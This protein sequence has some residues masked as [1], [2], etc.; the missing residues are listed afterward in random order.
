MRLVPHSLVTA[1]R[2]GRSDDYRSAPC[3]SE[4]VRCL[5]IG[6]A[7][8]CLL[9][10]P[11]LGAGAS[12]QG[13]RHLHEHGHPAIVLE[14]PGSRP[15]R[16]VTGAASPGPPGPGRVSTTPTNQ[17]L[18]ELAPEDT[19]SANLFDLRGRT[20]TFT[21]DGQGGYSRSVRSVAWEDDIGPAVADG[22][23]IRL[24]SF[25]FDFAS[26]R[27][28]SFFVSGRG[29]ISF[30]KRLTY[31]HHGIIENRYGT[32]REIAAKFVT[33]P[34]ISPLYKPY[35]GGWSSDEWTDAYGA[36]QHVRS[37]P[38]RVV[39]TWVTTEP[40]KYVHGVPPDEPSRFQVVLRADGSVQFNYQN[41]I[42]FGD[43]IVGLFPDEPDEEPTKGALIASIVDGS[44]PQLAGHLDLLEVAIYESST[45]SAIV[46]WT[47]RDQITAPPSGTR[48]SYRLHLDADEPYFE[49]D[50]DEEFE[51]QVDLESDEVRTRGGRLLPRKAGNRIALL[52]EDPG[53]FGNSMHARAGA[54]QFDDSGWVSGESLDPVLLEVPD[55][56]APMTDLSRSDSGF[57]KRQSE[58]FH[59]RGG[60]DYAD[61]V[62]RVID[63]LGDE[64]DFFVFHEEFVLDHQE[65]GGGRG[66][67]Y[68]SRDV[69]GIGRSGDRSPPCGEGRLKFG[70]SDWVKGPDVFYGGARR[71]NH[72]G[73]ES[74][75]L[76]FAHEITHWWTAYASYR[77][78]GMR[79]PLF[80]EYC[81]CHWRPELH[82]PAAFPWDPTSPGP[83]GF[84]SDYI[85]G[86]PAGFWRENADGTF[87]PITDYRGGGHSWLDLYMMGLADTDEVPDMFILRN[88][89]P[90]PGTDR[91]TGQ[92]ETVSIEQVVAAE[93]PRE[94]PAELAQK[95]FNVA[96][97]YVT[98]PGRT[99]DPDLLDLQREL[100]DRIV[101]H[102]AHVTGGRSR[103]TTTVP[104]VG[105]V[106]NRAPTVVGTLADRVVPVDGTAV[107]E[108]R[109]AFRDPDGDPLTYD[110]TSSAPAVASVAVSG[111]TVTLRA[112]AAGTAT[113]TVTATDVGASNTPATLAFRVTVREQAAFTDDPIVPGVTPVRAVHFTELR[114]RI[115]L[116]RS[117]AGLRPFSWTDPILTT[118]LTPVRLTHL[119]ELRGAL[120]A[121]Y[122]A[123]GRTA[124]TFTDP[125]P[126][127]GT[128]PI[129]AAHLTELRAAVLAL[130]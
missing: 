43:G 94:P 10:L 82:T 55:R 93:G 73:F 66:F 40:V 31:R 33:V 101:E 97:V 124:P 64:F 92:K 23:E 18:V 50:G 116:L 58:V 35:L 89:Q 114:E 1:L 60:L 105:D 9:A 78:N 62:C 14:G 125:A 4:C 22:E 28:D 84:M 76:L 126:T 56:A 39:V 38:D 107:V 112:V 128:T 26:R 45:G 127:A 30:G 110:A 95:V 42:F 130:R 75:L 37:S 102:W 65:R 81:G 6:V 54:H 25:T 122:T 19:T 8:A 63:I 103:V 13:A 11:L 15:V 96:F 44:N 27:W 36:T 83:G 57:S 46:E 119:L 90:V 98:E 20:L 106:G 70:Y 49:E 47:T 121:A 79:E 12:G 5:R 17:I 52:V 99:P 71:P 67:D 117:A 74:G 16:P 53:L 2:T 41:D 115:D 21:P 108:V 129:T 72:T 59:H 109:G 7:T 111:S 61:I 51:F 120:A 3:A 104:A 87:T 48:Y 34:T 88:L 113:V 123:S 69:S 91:Y 86:R 80:G 100:R 77:R 68:P 29:L 32:M 85:D 24:Q 118:G